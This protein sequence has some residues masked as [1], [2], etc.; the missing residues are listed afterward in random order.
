ML[1]P[2][3]RGE[4]V[5]W[6]KYAISEYD[7]SVSQTAGVLKQEPR[8]ARLFM[9]TDGRWK[10]MHA[11]GFRPMLFDLEGDPDELNDLG[12]DPAFAPEYER[13]DAALRHWQF[14]L[15]QRTTRS[16]AQIKGMRGRSLRRGV[17]IGVWD[18]SEVPE[19][20]WSGYFRYLQK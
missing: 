4:D 12:A 5:P 6:R 17:L 1:L 13:L 11:I 9:V 14:R 20:L 2:L 18:E 16:E 19:E 7:Y 8:D 15:S 10:Y 3:L